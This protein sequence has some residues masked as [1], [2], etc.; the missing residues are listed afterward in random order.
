MK[1][2]QR[3]SSAVRETTRKRWQAVLAV[4]LS[5]VM[6]AQSSNFQAIAANAQPMNE[7]PVE[8]AAGTDAD[9]RDTA[10]TEGETVEL[11]VET[12]D[13]TLTYTDETGEKN[14]TPSDETQS[15]DV[16]ADAEFTFS[17]TP[18]EGAEV[19]AVKYVTPDGAET[20]LAADENG[21]YT[22]SS[23]ADGATLEIVTGGGSS[24][25]SDGALAN[26]A[27]AYKRGGNDWSSHRAPWNYYEGT[28]TITKH[29][30]QG[31]RDSLGTTSVDL[32]SSWLGDDSADVSE[33]ALEDY[34]FQYASYGNKAINSFKISGEGKL[35]YSSN[36]G[37][38]WDEV[39][40]EDSIT[41][42]YKKSA[43]ASRIDVTIDNNKLYVGNSTTAHAQVWPED[44]SYVWSSS[45]PSVASVNEDG[46]VTGISSGYTLITA[47]S[48]RKSDSVPVRVL[49]NPSQNIEQTTYFYLVY[50]G[51]ENPSSGEG[52]WR[53][54]DWLYAGEGEASL[55]DAR[56]TDLRT[57]INDN[58]DSRITV[59]PTRYMS[60]TITIDGTTYR[61]D[62]EGTGE[63]G[64]F[65]VEWDKAIL[66]SGAN[67][68]NKWDGESQINDDTLASG[69]TWHIDGHLVL[70]DEEKVTVSFSVQDPEMES[71]ALIDGYLY[72]IKKGSDVSRIPEMDETKEY[73]GVTFTFDGWY[74][75]RDFTTKATEDD[76]KDVDDN[77]AFY[78][79]YVAELSVTYDWG[80]VDGTQPTGKP[81]GAQVNYGDEYT[82]DS[83]FTSES[84]FECV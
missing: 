14:V 35:L 84:T 38:S 75:D 42:Y 44:S 66:S 30:L 2:R 78:G 77:I 21:V 74:L 9:Q 6:V 53:P 24:E 36:N 64:T 67:N 58:L 26:S 31:E 54:G 34:E 12:P 13:A 71:P 49:G 76:F 68:S 27:S 23:V 11:N 45:K 41:F 69:N 33:L 46:T 83:T 73:G 22:V 72:T 81:A 29:Y 8:S 32:S 20:E 52:E 43:A 61:Y 55:P 48:G 51:V 70:N 19:S 63:P 47:T 4:I 80:T 37:H 1:H 62:S 18:A 82:P 7:N 57:I 56:S 10:V 5:V 28:L 15:I 59:Q 65:S 40:D 25:Q 79:R 17:V 3:G 50:P 16:P 39:E 60:K